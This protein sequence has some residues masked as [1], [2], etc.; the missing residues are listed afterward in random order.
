ML[1]LRHVKRENGKVTITSRYDINIRRYTQ[2][3]R[4]SSPAKRKNKKTR[5]YLYWQKCVS[6]LSLG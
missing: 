2:H 4:F 5:Y 3:P 1:T 6:H